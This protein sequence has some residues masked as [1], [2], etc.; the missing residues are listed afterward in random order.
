MNKS[1]SA[2]WSV[3]LQ[4]WQTNW[5]AL[6]EKLHIS[7]VGICNWSKTVTHNAHIMHEAAQLNKDLDL[8]VY[9]GHKFSVRKILEILDVIDRAVEWMGIW[10]LE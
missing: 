1:F 3:F 10:N 9:F 5:D 2:E 6:L 8:S 7:D 4:P